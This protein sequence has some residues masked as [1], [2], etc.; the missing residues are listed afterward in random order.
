MTDPEVKKA[1]WTTLPGVLTGVAALLAAVATLYTALHK[2]GSGPGS[3]APTTVHPPRP[4]PK[5]DTE[6]CSPTFALSGTAQGAGEILLLSR[7]SSAVGAKAYL[8]GKCQERMLHG[9]NGSA[10]LLIAKTP[11]GTYSIR[12]TKQGYIDF[13]RTVTVISGQRTEVD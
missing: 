9:S 4:K 5:P 3:P 1:F 6:P 13:T 12:V 10:I 8:D 2:G 11:S 7:D